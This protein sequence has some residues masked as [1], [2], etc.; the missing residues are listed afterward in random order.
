MPSHMKRMFL[1][2]N[3][4]VSVDVK[5]NYNVQTPLSN[6]LAS[7]F[8]Y[9]DN[10][11]VR[12]LMID[13][14]PWFVAKDVCDILEISKYRDA[15]SR[16]DDDERESVLVDTLGG[17]QEMGA[18]NEYGL[19]SLIMKSRKSE[20]K[21]FK[22]W[23]THEVIPSI[24]KSGKYETFTH[25]YLNMSEEDRAIAYFTKLKTEKE[26][27]LLAEQ[28]K[29]LVTFAETILKSEDTILVRDM[30]KVIKDEGIDIGEK[31]LYN[32][33]RDWNLVLKDNKP[34]Q[35]AVEHGWLVPQ[36]YS[37]TNSYNKEK[38]TFSSK[39]TPKGQV[40]I[41]NRIKKELE[42]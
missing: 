11:T 36:M 5:N 7:V 20:A 21:V 4:K 41:V 10:H 28:N 37:Y 14:E 22:K 13:N 15:L 12:T 34:S 26:L 39:I 31:K 25:D 2:M 17:K 3:N 29:P 42:K 18:V 32:K 38:I 16:L 1:I 8:S 27:I 35:Y 19:Y 30:A 6:V 33:L 9:N 40:Y 24:R 23:I